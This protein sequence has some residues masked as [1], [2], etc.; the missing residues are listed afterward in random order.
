MEASKRGMNKGRCL[1][2]LENKA[3]CLE[4]IIKLSSFY[5]IFLGR[6]PRLHNGFM[7]AMYRT[8][9]WDG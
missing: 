6:S 1:I 5:L 9:C 8:G 4:I 7:P 2:E 3:G